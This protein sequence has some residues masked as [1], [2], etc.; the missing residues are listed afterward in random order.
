LRGAPRLL[1]VTAVVGIDDHYS[2]GKRNPEN[3]AKGLRKRMRLK[4]TFSQQS[5]TRRSS[6]WNPQSFAEYLLDRHRRPALPFF[7]ALN[8]EAGLRLHLADKPAA[9]P[10][11]ALWLS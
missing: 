1:E 5:S 3:G 4:S 11:Q 2:G 7:A 8:R 6:V 9:E 10:S